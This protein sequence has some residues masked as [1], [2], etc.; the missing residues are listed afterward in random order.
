MPILFVNTRPTTRGVQLSHEL[1][2]ASIPVLDLPLLSIQSLAYQAKDAQKIQQLQAAYYTLLVVISPTAA[3]MGLAQCPQDY[4]PDCAVI[5]IGEA[6]AIVL[7]QAGWQVHCPKNMSNEGLLQMPI[8]AGLQTGQQVLIWRGEGGRRLLD[9][10]LQAMN[11]GVDSIAW[12]ARVCPSSLPQQYRQLCLQLN[13]HKNLLPVILISSGEALTHWQ[14]VVH[15][16][17]SSAH[18]H[19]QLS[20][21]YYLVLG[22]RLAN[23]LHKLGLQYIQ[24]NTLNPSHILQKLHSLK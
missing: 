22:E 3:R 14:H 23:Q 1:Q 15:T 24:L 13:E 6:T 4:V 19:P 21:F 5:A 17:D 9:D 20:D 18:L 2:M 16:T 8:I 7:R 11:V 10:H 12:Y